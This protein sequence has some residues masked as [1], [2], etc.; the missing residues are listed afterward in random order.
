MSILYNVTIAQPNTHLV[1]VEML[2]SN[3]NSSNITVAMPVWTPGSYMVREFS[4]HI[5]CI[6]AYAGDYS[7]SIEKIAKNKW[8]IPNIPSETIKVIYEVYAFEL[9]VRTSYVSDEFFLLNG[10][11]IFLYVEDY[12]NLRH[13]IAIHTTHF[14]QIACTL[15][16]HDGNYFAE[17]YNQLVDTPILGGQFD[18][19]T[20]L[21]ANIEHN[22]YILGR[23]NYN[24]SKLINDLQII[25]SY[26]IKMMGGIPCEN[27]NF[28]IIN[29]DKIY[30]GLEHTDCSVNMVPRFNYDKENYLAT[31]S[32]LAHEYFHLWNIKTISPQ[33]L[34]NFNYDEENYTRLLWFVEGITSFFDDYFVYKSGVSTLQEYLSIVARNINNTYN[35]AGNSQQSLGDASFDAWIKYYRQNENS[36]NNQVSYYIKGSVVAL[37]LHLYLL[38][39]SNGEK[40]LDDVMA[41]FY[42]KYI[43]NSDLGYTFESLI[44]W[45]KSCTNV[46]ISDFLIKYV[47][48]NQSLPIA[49]FLT[50]AGIELKDNA[51]AKNTLGIQL[52]YNANQC[53]VTYIDKRYPAYSQGLQYGDEII[54]VDGLRITDASWEKRWNEVNSNSTLQLTINRLGVLKIINITLAKNINH[55]YILLLQEDITTLQEKIRGRWL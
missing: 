50:Y 49:E 32:L 36:P 51:V 54:A 45:T 25:T 9:T 18:K 31:I 1:T 5:N 40:G 17:S 44:A 53:I 39:N 23:G 16:Q 22:I 47:E 11:S 26:E 30:G 21:S 35:L 7:L 12:R 29:T 37:A 43:D 10:A 6:R 3:I 27:Y 34:K 48:D 14:D 20:F 33:T 13:T 52:Q 55:E 8:T 15:S 42:T 24:K 4:R 19:A 38:Q 28:Y 2:I 41:Y 46:D